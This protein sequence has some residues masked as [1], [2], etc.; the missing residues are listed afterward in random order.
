MKA[1]NEALSWPMVGGLVQTKVNA[2]Q[3]NLPVRSGYAVARTSKP[4]VVTT[5]W[6]S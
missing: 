1:D 4:R 2:R 3:W 6:W 5:S